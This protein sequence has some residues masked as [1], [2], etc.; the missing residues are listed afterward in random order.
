MKIELRNEILHTT[1]SISENQNCKHKQIYQHSISCM[2]HVHGK[3]L[4]SEYSSQYLVEKGV[5]ELAYK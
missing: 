4:R 3:E 1:C 5:D 2:M